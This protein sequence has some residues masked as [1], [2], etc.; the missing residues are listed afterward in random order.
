MGKGKFYLTDGMIK[1]AN[2]T[3]KKL[4]SKVEILEVNS[5]R[6]KIEYI[7]LCDEFDD[8][9]INLPT[10][11]IQFNTANCSMSFKKI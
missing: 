9:Y 1:N 6:D 5:L 7:A 4:L 8:I 2:N 3:V 11:E 10:Y